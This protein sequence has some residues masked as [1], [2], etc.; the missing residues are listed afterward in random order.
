MA[1]RGEK[2][3]RLV[4]YK[5]LGKGILWKH[6]GYGGRW[7][8]RGHHAHA[9]L[10]APRDATGPRHGA[11]SEP[12]LPPS[13]VVRLNPG[14]NGFGILDTRTGNTYGGAWNKVRAQQLWEA[15][16]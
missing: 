13:L 1:L 14:P 8:V 12:D 5:N 4:G 10:P 9:V 7:L 2:W 6:N 3:S 16:Q 15:L 11:P